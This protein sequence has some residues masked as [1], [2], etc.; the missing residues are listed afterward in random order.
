ML[1]TSFEH[2]SLPCLTTPRISQPLDTS[3]LLVI[4]HIKNY[5]RLSFYP[6]L[7]VFFHSFKRG[8]LIPRDPTMPPPLEENKYQQFSIMHLCLQIVNMKSNNDKGQ[9]A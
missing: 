7:S 2:L 9:E 8:H 5:I 3:I 1:A 4:S 6:K